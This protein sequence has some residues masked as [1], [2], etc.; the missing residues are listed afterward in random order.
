MF[1][2]TCICTETHVGK[3][4]KIFSMKR[5]LTRNILLGSRSK[6]Y[7]QCEFRKKPHDLITTVKKY[8]KEGVRRELAEL[9]E[10]WKLKL[11]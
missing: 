8:Q 2:S 9:L 10:K 5:T 1:F 6:L 11:Q 3:N 4:K 7:F